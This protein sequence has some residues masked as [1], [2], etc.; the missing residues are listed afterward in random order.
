MNRASIDPSTGARACRWRSATGQR[1]LSL[2]E[3]MLAMLLGLVMLAGIIQFYQGA[4][5]THQVTVALAELNENA[6]FALDL[7]ARDLRMAGYYSCGGASAQL[8]N[9]LREP[10]NW[11]A[12]H[13]GLEGF[14]GASEHL[15]AELA[16]D[17]L[18]GTDAL[19]VRRAAVTDVVMITAHYPNA[20]SP[21]FTTQGGSLPASGALIVVDEQG[22]SQVTI[23]QAM[24]SLSFGNNG[25]LF[26]GGS[27]L[28]QPGIC[29]TALFGRF[30]CGD[31]SSAANLTFSPGSRIARLRTRAYYVSAGPPPTLMMRELQFDPTRNQLVAEPY[32]LV[33]NVEQ[34]QLRYGVPADSGRALADQYVSAD[35]VSDWH[36]VYAVE[37]A[38]LLRASNPNLL[39]AAREEQ[40]D[41]AG[42]RVTT[43]DRHL[44]KAFSMTVALR[45]VLP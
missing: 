8:A 22:C 18:A 5:I 32:P 35:E 36:E 44:R 25:W 28:R 11:H 23:M 31:T 12:R 29:T 26:Y 20:T 1:G 13:A 42:T 17:A 33:R 7:L 40:F 30:D 21:Y 43:N 45:N 14:A 4:R 16:T 34:L 39:S 37:I 27:T 24:L 19:I 6:R 15:P 9:V 41:L 2:V 3:I 10:E 38:L